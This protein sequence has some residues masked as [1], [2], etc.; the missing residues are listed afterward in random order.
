VAE[1]TDAAADGPGPRVLVVT[2]STRASRGEY[3]DRSGPEA[4]AR[5]QRAGFEVHGP[6]VV[7]DGEP[8]GRALQDAVAAG[9]D[10]VVTTGGTGLAASDETPERT[11][12]VLEREV[13]GIAEA[14]RG[15]GVAAG[16]PTAV[17]SR[18]VAGTVGSTLVVNLPGS[19]GG[20]R[21]GV[22]LLV[23]LL[24]HA[25]DQLHGGDH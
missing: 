22:D 24:R 10:V 8:V 23:P 21:D 11:R 13:P 2:A 1:A 4:V 19:I 14:L 3:A 6:V 20:V 9:Y 16:V 12:A 15:A 18:G 7:A 5:L 25:V 17:L